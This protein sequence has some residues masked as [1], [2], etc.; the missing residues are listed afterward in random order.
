MSGA[1]RDVVFAALADG[2]RRLLLDRL[3]MENGQTLAQL[4]KGLGVLPHGVRRL[5]SRLADHRDPGCAG[6]SGQ[7]VPVRRLRVAVQQPARR[8]QMAGHARG[9]LLRESTQLLAD[10]AVQL[11]TGDGGIEL[12]AVVDRLFRGALRALGPS[13][14][15]FGSRTPAIVPHHNLRSVHT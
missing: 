3:R 15:P 8:N 9:E 11:L 4:A 5:P 10:V 14:P 7:V 13:L 1:D 12:G 2:H 6:S